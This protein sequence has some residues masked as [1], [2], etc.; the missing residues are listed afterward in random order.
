ML[1]SKD[2]RESDASCLHAHILKFGLTVHIGIRATP[3]PRRRL[4]SDADTSRLDILDYLGNSV[5][6]IDF[7]TE[8]KY[9]GSIARHSLTSDADVDKHIR[10]ASAAFEALKKIMTYKDIDFKVK[11]KIYVEL[12]L[13]ILL[14]G[15]EIWCLK[16]DLFNHLRH[17]HHRCARIKRRITIA[18][19]I[20]HRT[21][22][23]TLFTSFAIEPFDTNYN[24]R[25]LRWTGHVVRVILIQEN[26]D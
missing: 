25:L 18:Y 9:L 26:I 13:S 21:S 1:N 17:F 14:Y 22:S 12:C 19:T 11:G 7:T 4:Y 15:S 24:R 10:P 3:P 5:G 6:F 2:D 23:A 16:E 8:F 20:R